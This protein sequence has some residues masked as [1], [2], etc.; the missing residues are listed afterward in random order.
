[1]KSV[2]M[3]ALFAA[4]ALALTAGVTT[5]AHAGG[6]YRQDLSA[7]QA[8][9]AYSGAVTAKGAAALWWNPASIAGS[10]RKSGV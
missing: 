10:D 4:S 1:M 7:K 6:F 3:M 5:A 9:N 2:K 8:G